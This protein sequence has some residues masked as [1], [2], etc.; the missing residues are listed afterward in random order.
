MIFPTGVATDSSNNVYVTS[1][2]QVWK[3]TSDGT[4]IRKRGS[5]GQFDWPRG[6]AI[7]SSNNVY[8]VDSPVYS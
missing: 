3:F 8:V 1:N 6:I 2:Q 5:T 7:D 4:F